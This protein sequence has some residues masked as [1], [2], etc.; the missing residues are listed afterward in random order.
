MSSIRVTCLGSTTR[1]DELRVYFSKPEHGGGPVEKIYY[2]L[3]NNDAV[4]VFQESH[5]AAQVMSIE[6]H[7]V[8]GREVDMYFL[9]PKI[10][11]TIQ[12]RV[13]PAVSLL[14]ESVTAC[15]DHLLYIIGL[16]LTFDSAGCCILEGNM[17]QIEMG[18]EII[19][20]YLHQQEKI[21][22]R[23]LN[24]GY[25]LQKSLSGSK[26]PS[27]NG[28]SDRLESS[29]RFLSSN[30]RQENQAP[31]WS[32]SDDRSLED[33]DENGA[34]FREKE[35][36]KHKESSISDYRDRRNLPMEIDHETQVKSISGVSNVRP[37]TSPGAEW[38]QE[39]S[40][41]SESQLDDLFSSTHKSSS[42]SHKETDRLFTKSEKVPT[43][44]ESHLRSDYK[45]PTSK[46]SF[47]NENSL[48]GYQNQVDR[49]L[50]Y[51]SL[52][53][54]N[55]RES[56]Q[57]FPSNADESSEEESFGRGTK[58]FD[59][60]NNT[61][62]NFSSLPHTSRQKGGASKSSKTTVK[63]NSIM[64][65]SN[66]ISIKPGTSSAL[67]K[68]AKPSTNKAAEK[69][70][71]SSS[72]IDRLLSSHY[73]SLEP[74]FEALK[75]SQRAALMS[76]HSQAN[77]FTFNAGSL[78]VTVCQG[79]ITEVNTVAIVNA[80][81]GSLIN[82][83][84]VAGAIAR[85]ASPTM[86]RECE[87]FVKKNGM[88]STGEIMHTRAG[89]RL[90]DRVTHVLHAVGP[91]WL[92]NLPDRCLYEL[93]LTY[94]NVF[95]YANKLW[96]PSLAL[97]CI[98][99]GV[100]GAPLD[101]SIKCFLDGVL[102]FHSEM[103]DP[104]HLKEITLVNTD[105]DGV[106][107]S[108]AILQSLLDGGQDR[109]T[110]EAIDRFTR[111]QEKRRATTNKLKMVAGRSLIKDD[112][113]TDTGRK[114]DLVHNET[115]R[116][117]RRSSSMSR[118][119]AKTESATSDKKVK[120]DSSSK[121]M[122][123]SLRVNGSSSNLEKKSPRP[124]SSNRPSSQAT[125]TKQPEEQK[126]PRQPPAM[127]PALVT[128]SPPSGGAK[129]KTKTTH[130]TTA[131]NTPLKAA[132]TLDPFNMERELSKLKLNQTSNGAFKSYTREY[133]E[134]EFHSLPINLESPSVDKISFCKICHGK[135]KKSKTL[136][137]CNHTFCTDCIEGQFRKYGPKCPQCGAMYSTSTLSKT[138]SEEVESSPR[139][140]LMSTVVHSSL[141]QGTMSHMTRRNMSVPGYEYC[142]GA[143]EIQYDIPSGKVLRKDRSS[144]RSAYTGVQHKAYLPNSAE[145]REILRL[146]K[147][148]FEADLVFRVS[149]RGTVE[150]CIS[151]K[152][153]IHA[154]NGYP[155]STYLRKVREELSRRGIT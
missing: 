131:K 130:N 146:L 72:V 42:L 55:G 102:I 68:G 117:R 4:I 152:T 134:E 47:I 54:V 6:E 22:S 98:S 2:P 8:A 79:N 51:L 129:P 57:V 69:K 9:P 1:E 154:S 118:L 127:K 101:V 36:S 112:I 67:E 10:F 128:T 53:S 74:Q 58:R 43:S 82:G 107:T 11:S 87:E 71:S 14:I 77:S 136:Y 56:I 93:I 149:S 143:I 103:G 48:P 147:K 114:T 121:K 88:L 80:A 140:Q 90:P 115:S 29:E 123:S 138:M 45:D 27:H 125:Y 65:E 119:K 116:A 40:K 44:A 7:T 32:K 70:D 97:P 41:Y 145:G 113:T 38:T 91:I 73:S 81:N 46:T 28:K 96:I 99:S 148:A 126:S 155:D 64:K 120:E 83:A 84:G 78:K 105:E 31:Y 141:P 13:D 52:Q 144:S 100:F 37:I 111:L 61:F 20:R 106:A 26:Q 39:L 34:F 60:A 108:I 133:N 49:P 95:K 153:S 94:V 137:K 33:E 18:W 76:D 122:S 135:M 24:K 62:E 21:H 89:G 75:H 23:A 132:V 63:S 30:S 124:P 109:A 92:D 3:M 66:H 5:V 17:F 85:A 150:W 151:H 50:D 16:S 110:A 59:D 12:A 139:S 142:E 86:E 25:N 104:A 19:G 15:K 35:V